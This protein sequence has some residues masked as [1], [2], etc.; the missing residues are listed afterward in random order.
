MLWILRQVK[1]GLGVRA[2]RNPVPLED[3]VAGPL[4]GGAPKL[5]I[6]PV[7]IGLLIVCAVESGNAESTDAVR[8]SEEFVDLQR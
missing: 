5:L 1:S 7:E 2:P 4:L 3:N 8:Y 6:E